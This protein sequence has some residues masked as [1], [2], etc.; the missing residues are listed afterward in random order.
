[1]EDLCEYVLRGFVCDV[2]FCIVDKCWVCLE[3]RLVDDGGVIVF[4]IDVMELC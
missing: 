2:S 1:M 4:L 3:I